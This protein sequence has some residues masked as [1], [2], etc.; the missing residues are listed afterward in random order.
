MLSLVELQIIKS[1]RYIYQNTK[2][3]YLRISYISDCTVIRYRD[4]QTC[5]EHSTC[6]FS[7]IFGEVLKKSFLRWIPPCRWPAKTETRS[8]FTTRMYITVSN[9]TSFVD[10]NTVTYLSARNVD[11]FLLLLLLFRLTPVLPWVRTREL[12]SDF[13]SSV[14][15][16]CLG[17]AF[18]IVIEGNLSGSSFLVLWA[19]VWVFFFLQVRAANPTPKPP[20]WRTRA[21]L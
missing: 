7:T 8:M 6:Y 18:L 11:N 3:I 5:G 17:C 2:K 10:V 15:T 21:S 4:I 16:V 12:C 20:T 14:F 1:A 13:L 19:I 9:H